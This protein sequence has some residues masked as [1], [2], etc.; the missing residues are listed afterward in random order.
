MNKRFHPYEGQSGQ[1]GQGGERY[2]C[3]DDGYGQP[4]L[5]DR[6]KRSFRVFD[7]MS[8]V[9]HIRRAPK[10]GF[11][12][13]ERIILKMKSLK[14]LS[15]AND[16]PFWAAKAS[17]WRGENTKR[18]RMTR[19]ATN[20]PLSSRA[21]MPTPPVLL[22]SHHAP[23]TLI[24][25]EPKGG[26]IQFTTGE[27]AVEWVRGAWSYILWDQTLMGPNPLNSTT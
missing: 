19:A 23:S 4:K 16:K 20:E 21:M 10:K 2:H 25:K 3:L 8:Q 9:G 14:P 17:A 12:D 11:H 13:P 27:T 6:G 26:L 24:F 1:S 5:S 22:S 18:N 7:N 15:I